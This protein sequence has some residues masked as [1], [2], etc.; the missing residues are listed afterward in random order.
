[1]ETA[2]S[3][4]FRVFWGVP[5]ILMQANVVAPIPKMDHCP[6]KR[7]HRGFGSMT[8]MLWQDK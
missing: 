8:L 7:D 5:L 3:Q 4:E 6:I 2:G 1:M